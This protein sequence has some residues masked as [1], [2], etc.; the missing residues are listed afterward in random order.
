[1]ENK[2]EDEKELRIITPIPN[3]N[4]LLMKKLV[5]KV[6]KFRRKWKSGK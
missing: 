2:N 5:T 1:M 4:P 6:K 3:P